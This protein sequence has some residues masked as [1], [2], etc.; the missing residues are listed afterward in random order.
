METFIICFTILL[1][2]EQDVVF[3]CKINDPFT[4]NNN[5]KTKGILHS[6]S[7]FLIFGQ[8]WFPVEG[9]QV[10]TSVFFFATATS[11]AIY[12]YPSCYLPW[13]LFRL[14]TRDHVTNPL[15]FQLC[16]LETYISDASFQV[17]CSLNSI[18]SLCIQNAAE[19]IGK[20]RPE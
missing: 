8:L 2:N 9:T 19:V 18:L 16:S 14:H 1:F 15:R 20:T 12:C 3:V 10:V 13:P 6:L 17:R 7:F 4:I 11:A 5:N